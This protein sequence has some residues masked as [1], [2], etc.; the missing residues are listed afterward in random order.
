LSRQSKLPEERMTRVVHHV[1]GRAVAVDP[2]R[3][4]LED[5]LR[6]L[7]LI[8]QQLRAQCDEAT[9]SRFGE[10]EAGFSIAASLGHTLLT[11]A[12]ARVVDQLS[13]MPGGAR[14]VC[15][16][17]GSSDVPHLSDVQ[18]LTD[19]D[20]RAPAPDRPPVAAQPSAFGSG[21]VTLQRHSTVA[22]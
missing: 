17:L 14:L 5:A 1:S 21:R 15:T 8:D 2:D 3:D 12:E 20:E 18:W 13:R 16:Y 11:T 9:L 4:A 7:A 6:Q 10:A 22:P 19:S